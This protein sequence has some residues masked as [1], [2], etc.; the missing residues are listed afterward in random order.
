VSK[1]LLDRHQ[2][3]RFINRTGPL[4]SLSPPFSPWPAVGSRAHSLR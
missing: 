2:S 3:P 1:L 4:Q